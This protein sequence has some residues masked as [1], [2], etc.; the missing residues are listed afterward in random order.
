MNVLRLVPMVAAA[1]FMILEHLRFNTDYVVNQV[2]DCLVN[3]GVR[4][5]DASCARGI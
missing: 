2:D 5:A 1:G 3:C 4:D